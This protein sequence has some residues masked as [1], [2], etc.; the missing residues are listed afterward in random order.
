MN[1]WQNERKKEASK[2][3]KK[4]GRREGGRKERRKKETEKEKT[5]EAK[6][7]S[8]REKEEDQEAQELIDHF[9]RRKED[10]SIY[11]TF[12]SVYLTLAEVDCAI[13]SSTVLFAFL[14][15]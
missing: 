9:C 8:T 2:E 4:E 3:G 6:E 7:G 15:S 1:E 13:F 5:N 14:L 12:G 10:L 11:F